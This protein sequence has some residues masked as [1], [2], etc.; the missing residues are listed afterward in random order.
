MRQDHRAGTLGILC[1]VSPLSLHPLERDYRVL[2]GQAYSQPRPL[3]SRWHRPPA[4]CHLCEHRNCHF[5]K[6]PVP[7]CMGGWSVP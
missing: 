2:P 7:S 4:T 6:G 3:L 1:Q 5:T